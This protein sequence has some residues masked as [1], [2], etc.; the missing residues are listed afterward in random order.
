MSHD[1]GKEKHDPFTL[2]IIIGLRANL[3]IKCPRK[4][5]LRCAYLDLFVWWSSI[6]L[7]KQCLY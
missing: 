7:T 2:G 6:S 1:S 5:Y 3:S 4:L